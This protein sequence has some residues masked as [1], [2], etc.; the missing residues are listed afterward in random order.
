MSQDEFAT[1]I[2]R[3]TSFSSSWL[4]SSAPKRDS[5]AAELERDPQLSTAKR[6]QRT[7]VF[8]SHMAHASLER[9][10]LAAQTAKSE[11]EIK[12]REKDIEIDRLRGDVHALAD[13]EKEEREGRDYERTEREEEKRKSDSSIRALRVQ[14]AD[15]ESQYAE[16]QDTYSTQRR[17]WDHANAKKESQIIELERRVQMIKEELVEFQGIAASRSN[18]IKELQN[19]LH[20]SSVVQDEVAQH[21]MNSENWKL[22][23]E[24][25]HRQANYLRVIESENAKM[26]AEL[27]TLRKRQ[28]DVGI[29]KEQIRELSMKAQ[30]AEEAREQVAMLEAKLEATRQEAEESFLHRP[31]SKSMPISA[32]KN[33]SELRANLAR[34]AEERDTAVAVV[35]C[36]D[37]ELADVQARISEEE[38]ALEKSKAELQLLKSQADRQMRRMQLSEREVRYLKDMLASYEAEASEEGSKTVDATSESVRRMEALVTDYKA[39][40]DKLE[41]EIKDLGGDPSTLGGGRPRQ[42]LLDELKLAK[43]ATTKAEQALLKAEAATEKHLEQIEELEQT[44]FELQGEIGGGRHV[45]PGVRVLSLADNPAQQWLDLSQAA[46]ERLK[47]ENEALLNRLRDL[48]NSGVVSDPGSHQDLVPRESWEAVTREKE[49]L[50]DTLK[51]KEKRLMRLQQ[52]FAAKSEEFK[53]AIASILG[54]KLAFYPNGQVRVT[55]QFDLNAAFV[56]QPA[57]P[58]DDMRMQLVA[59]G[60]GGPQDLPQLMHYWVEQEQCIPGFLAS[61]TLE[62]YEK[63]KNEQSS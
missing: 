49:D 18:T 33:L 1:P 28:A 32:V 4:R 52:V 12:L 40:I 37:K 5:L 7:Q 9:Q 60:D 8:T 47:T 55:S 29:L 27:T 43:S 30:G 6:K 62:C 50:E 45:P 61:V 13:K 58:N 19:Q 39:T 35:L 46:M 63:S 48:E 21:A 36:R 34:V 20:E 56:F 38:I 23:S 3:S 41:A 59:R 57:G 44:L 25:L 42:E 11:L 17:T 24:E 31:S 54:V 26:K 14:V 51:Q 16:L 15:L 10:L 22:V 2:N 53:E